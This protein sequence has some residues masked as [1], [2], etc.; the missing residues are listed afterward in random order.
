MLRL[1]NGNGLR[2]VSFPHRHDCLRNQN[3]VITSPSVGRLDF[4]LLPTT[5]RLFRHRSATV[6]YSNTYGVVQIRNGNPRFSGIFKSRLR[7][8]FDHVEEHRRASSHHDGLLC[9]HH[10]RKDLLVLSPPSNQR[11][12]GVRFKED[13]LELVRVK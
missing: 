5:I 4:E 2:E 6:Q 12:V 13:S 3:W 1:E 10:T 11:L 8:C 9:E 7:R